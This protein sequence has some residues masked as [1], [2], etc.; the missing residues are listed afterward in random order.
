MARAA[1]VRTPGGVPASGGERAISIVLGPPAADP[2]ET[3]PGTWDGDPPKPE[4]WEAGGPE[5]LS[6]PTGAIAASSRM[7][8]GRLTGSLGIALGA[9]D[10]MSSAS[11]G[12]DTGA[13]AGATFLSARHLSQTHRA[14]PIS[15][16]MPRPIQISFGISQITTNTPTIQPAA[17]CFLFL[18]TW[19]PA[20][21]ASLKAIVTPEAGPMP[22]LRSRLKP[23]GEPHLH[24]LRVERRSLE[25]AECALRL[26]TELDRKLYR[27]GV[28][29]GSPSPGLPIPRAIDLGSF[30]K[31]VGF[32]LVGVPGPQWTLR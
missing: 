1:L 29:S 19:P 6:G 13:V 5:A 14:N 31:H 4:G 30:G 21:G 17:D 11:V 12:S 2:C 15:V 26:F 32:P 9:E 8:V 24:R 7:G 20:Y 16:A 10:W 28:D 25:V 3:G 23:A 18:A 22:S 27:D